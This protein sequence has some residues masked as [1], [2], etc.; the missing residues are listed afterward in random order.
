MRSLN[1]LLNGNLC[2]QVAF[3]LESVIIM[4]KF[5][6]D[7]KIELLRKAREHDLDI[8]ISGWFEETGSLNGEMLEDLDLDKL[9]EPIN[10]DIDEIVDYNPN[11]ITYGVTN[12]YDSSQNRENLSKDE[13]FEYLDKLLTK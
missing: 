10:W 6:D 1:Y 7:E 4:P 13:L 8:I 5:T 2:K 9:S 3:L 12:D 11:T